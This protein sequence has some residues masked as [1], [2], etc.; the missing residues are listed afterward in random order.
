M[1]IRPLKDCPFADPDRG[2]WEVSA[3]ASIFDFRPLTAST[4]EQLDEFG[5]QRRAVRRC[6]ASH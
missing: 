3:G 5:S 4:G 1:K 2:T 6:P